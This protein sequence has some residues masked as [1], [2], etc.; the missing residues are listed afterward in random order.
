MGSKEVK[1]GRINPED[2]PQG[3]YWESGTYKERMAR[4]NLTQKGN[5]ILV[6][7]HHLRMLL[8]K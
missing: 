6:S 8:M 1:K 7:L 5:A 3:L 4:Q 2:W